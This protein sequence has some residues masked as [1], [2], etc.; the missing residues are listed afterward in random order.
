[1]IRDLS[2]A[3][4]LLFALILAAVLWAAAFLLIF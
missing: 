2:P 3:G 1:M 4:G